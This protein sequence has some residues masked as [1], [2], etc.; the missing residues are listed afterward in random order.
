M[1][2]LVSR[3]LNGTN[4][5]NGN[6]SV[7]LQREITL[8]SKEWKTLDKS[9]VR[10]IRYVLFSRFGKLSPEYIIRNLT[11]PCVKVLIQSHGFEALFPVFCYKLLGC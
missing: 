7:Q 8:M 6:A 10:G 3:D 4:V 11:L 9:Q 5:I 1:A 2:K